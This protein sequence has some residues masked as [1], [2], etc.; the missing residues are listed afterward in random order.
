MTVTKEQIY[1]AKQIP[2]IEFLRQYR[3]SDLM[4]A[5]RD[6][7]QLKSHDSFKINGH[8]SLWHWKSRDIGGR[9]ALD[10]LIKV[11]GINFTDAVLMLC[12]EKPAPVTA[13]EKPNNTLPFALPKPSHNNDRV[14]AY[15]T[16]RGISEDV[17]KRCI[18][19][20]M[21]Y[22]SAKHHNAVFVG[23]DGR[24]I[25]RYAF[26]RGTYTKG[27][28]FKLE[29]PDSDRDFPFCLPSEESTK[30]IAV[31]ES[32][33]DAMAHLTL[34]KHADKYRLSLG[35]V[36][37]PPL[38]AFLKRHPEV[39]EIEVCMDNDI[40]GRRAAELIEKTYRDKYFVIRNLPVPEGYDYADIAKEV[41]A[42]NNDN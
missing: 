27:R 23:R 35:G 38:D 10:F 33:I 34:E 37:L 40:Q 6:E 8:T 21:L 28:P 32:A 15:L 39:E 12:G 11:D 20:G 5:G 26:M 18:Q 17:I 42:T 31:Y 16:G 29:V 13:H 30:R 3:Q 36:S 41:Y 4:K 1:S 22:E 24:G 19:C 14:I 25:P 9:S 7:Y 2:A